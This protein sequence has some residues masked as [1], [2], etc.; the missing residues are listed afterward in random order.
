VQSE[1]IVDMDR[2]QLDGNALLADARAL[3]ARS[4]ATTTPDARRERTSK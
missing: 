1:W 2:R 3:L 4:A